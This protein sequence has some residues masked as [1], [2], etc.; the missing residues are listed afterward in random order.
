MKKVL[1]V[2]FACLAADARAEPLPRDDGYRGIWYMN[3]PTKDEYKYKYSGGMATYPQQHTPIAVYSKEANKT[4]FVYGGTPKGKNE[5]LHMISYYDHA[6]GQVP[7][8]VILLNKKTDDAH[9]NPTLQIDDQGHLWIFSNAHGKGRPS[10]IHKGTKPHSIDEFEHILT[11]NFSYSQPWWVPGKGFLFLHTRYS[12]GRNLF[13]VTSPDG[14]KWGEPQPLARVA[15]GHYQISWRDGQRVATAFNYHPKQGGLNAR[16]NLY[17]AETRDMGQTWRTVDGKEIATP[18]AEVKNPA[19]VRDYEAAKLLVYLK[20]L[21]FDAKGNPVLL[22]LTSKGYAP[23]PAAGP[24]A[25]Q[26][27]RW[28]G[29]DW[30]VRPF[31]TSDHNYDFGSLYI[32]ADGAWR[33]IAPTEP[34]PQPFGTGGEMVLWTSRDEGK[35]W[36]KDR[37]LTRDS[38][39]N[40]SYARRPLNAHPD[41]YALWA[42]GNAREPSESSLYFTNRTGD[43]VWRLPAV[44]AGDFARPEVVGERTQN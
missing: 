44:M 8:P 43:K 34:G 14:R 39:C 40:H 10:Y 28:T 7:R 18:L 35:T 31:T 5:L 19:L 37:Q 17:Y 26:T 33:V 12:P 6:T 11:T 42:D 30:D 25:W 24:H 41:F 1:V 20:D 32:E 4:F 23:G 29:K 16:T 9:D 13:W 22:Y 27:A 21:Q 2:V 15:Q 36:N 38:R 3:Q